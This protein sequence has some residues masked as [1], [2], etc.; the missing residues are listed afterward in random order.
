MLPGCLY[1]QFLSSTDNDKLICET[2][3][4]RNKRKPKGQKGQNV[5][6]I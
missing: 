1:Q 6:V 4:Q 3:K 2:D 5:I